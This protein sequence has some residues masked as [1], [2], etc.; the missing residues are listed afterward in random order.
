MC[1]APTTE[2]GIQWLRRQGLAEHVLGCCVAIA[3]EQP[4]LWAA[5][6]ERYGAFPLPVDAAAPAPSLPC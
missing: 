4:G 3:R 5:T 6:R 1:T 2:V